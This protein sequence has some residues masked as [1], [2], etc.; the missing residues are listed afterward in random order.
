MNV[1]MKLIYEALQIMV[2]GMAGIFAVLGIIYLASVAL[3]KIFPE[4]K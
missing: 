1:D 4:E 2:E 3:L